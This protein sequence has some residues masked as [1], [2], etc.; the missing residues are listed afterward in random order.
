MKLLHWMLAGIVL[1]TPIGTLADDRKPIRVIVP[2]GAGG[3]LDTVTRAVVGRMAVI[4]DTAFVVEN[5]PGANANVAAAYVARAPSD[6]HVLLATGNYVTIN[7]QI[8]ANLAW[9]PRQLT[10]VARFA[11]AP[12]VLVVPMA[13]PYRTLQD[14]LTAAKKDRSISIAEAGPGAPQTMVTLVLA[15]SASVR[16]LAVQYAQ[17][18][19][20]IVSDLIGGRIDMTVMPMNVALGLVNA[21]QVRALAITSATR[22]SQLPDT[23]TM[24]ETGVPAAAIN[25]WVGFHAPAGTPPEMV[26]RLAVALREATSDE[27]VKRALANTGNQIEY[28]DTTSFAAFLNGNAEQARRLAKLRTAAEGVPQ[29]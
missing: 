5:K 9:S 24:A 7:P 6:G 11:L 29:Q 8:E 3:L 16:F 26:R 14:L 15:N 23:P 1:I 18:A 2:Y 21:G 19:T 27:S 13:S 28:L 25:S 17:G 10:P 20:S 4:M 12:N 22:S